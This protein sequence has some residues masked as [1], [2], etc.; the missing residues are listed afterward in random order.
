M[1]DGKKMKYR[2]ALLLKEHYKRIWRDMQ[3]NKPQDV[4]LKFFS[5]RTNEDLKE[6]YQKI[7]GDFDAFYVSG[8][9]P[10]QLLRNIGQEEKETLI[11]NAEIDVQNTYR[12][13]LRHLFS[14]D[15]ASI[16][17]IGIDFLRFEDSLEKVI[18]EDRLTEVVRD[19]ERRWKNFHTDEELMQEELA[20]SA[21]YEQQIKKGEIDFIITYFQSAKETAQKL[22]I[23]GDYVYPDMRAFRHSMED[24]KKSILLKQLH[25]K[26]PAAVYVDI[27]GEQPELGEWLVDTGEALSRRYYNKLIVKRNGDQIEYYTDSETLQDFTSGFTQCF[28]YEPLQKKFHFKGSVGYGIGENIYQARIN[29]MDAEHYGRNGGAGTGG[30]FLLDESQN[31]TVLG[32]EGKM[33]RRQTRVSEEYVQKIADEVRLSAETIV[34]IQGVMDVLQTKEIT[35]HDLVRGLG[36]SLRNANKFLGRM[37]ECQKASI[38]GK[39]RDGNKGRPINIYR[40]DF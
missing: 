13:M 27:R 4:E 35:S 29:A 22:G 40:I 30:S 20:V 26:L 3:K 11:A 36:I 25:K 28:L 7:K 15:K 16:S 5:Y 17:R 19:Y 34:R 38:V 2:I 39:K 18:E 23:Q 12:C 37:E 10:M 21:F 6:V 31:L 14:S 8:I 33:P 9:I 32:T 1:K 24:L